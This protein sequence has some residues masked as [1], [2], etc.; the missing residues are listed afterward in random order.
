MFH[1]GIYAAEL[2]EDIK[3]EVDVAL[4]IENRAYVQWLNSLEQTL[5]TEIIKE[6]HEVNIECPEDG[7]IDL[8]AIEVEYNQAAIRYEDV[9]TVFADDVQL[10]QSTLTS[11]AIFDNTYCKRDDKLLL[12]CDKDNI[13]VI[14]Y[15]RPALKGVDKNGNVQ[16]GEIMLPIEFIELVSTRLRGEAYRIMNENSLAANWLNE[17]NMILEN[18]KVWI[19]DKKP[20]FGM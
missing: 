19:A 9:Y 16:S 7:I 15:I 17:H 13:R 11:G 2:I 1:S 14:Y 18:F 8:S 20:Q 3:N 10:I 12:N 6:Q 5:Y 4:P